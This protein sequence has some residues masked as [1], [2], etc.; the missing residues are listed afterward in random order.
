VILVPRVAHPGFKTFEQ[1]DE[2][3]RMHFPKFLPLGMKQSYL[4][5][6]K[7]KRPTKQVITRRQATVINMT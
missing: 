5:K 3:S 6:K 4:K 7:K 2:T 1:S